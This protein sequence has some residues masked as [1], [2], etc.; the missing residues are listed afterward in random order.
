MG[1]DSNQAKK[2]TSNRTIF[3][4][5]GVEFSG[6]TWL[7]LLVLVAIGIALIINYWSRIENIFSKQPIK[8]TQ[9]SITIANQNQI[10]KLT[11]EGG[12]LIRQVYKVNLRDN[13]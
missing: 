1:K 9:K 5:L 12:Y 6:P 2:K 3:K 4:I 7:A 8:D 10:Y 11:D 13:E